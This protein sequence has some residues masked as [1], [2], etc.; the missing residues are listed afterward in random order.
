MIT[1]HFYCSLVI[2]SHLISVL[3]T[4]L[5]YV[6][7][8]WIRACFDKMIFLD[9]FQLMKLYG[10]RKSLSRRSII[11]SER[12][13]LRSETNIQSIYCL[14]IYSVAYNSSAIWYS[15][16]SRSIYCTSVWYRS[17][18]CSYSFSWTNIPLGIET[19]VRTFFDLVFFFGLF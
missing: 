3:Y 17:I 7:P 13:I 10:M 14:G 2:L 11:F 9:L 19:I 1:L 16:L 5:L 4:I 18:T 8:H 6:P 12:S 15:N